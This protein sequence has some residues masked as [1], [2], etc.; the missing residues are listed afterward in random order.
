MMTDGA[1]THRMMKNGA[2]IEK[3]MMI[4]FATFKPCG[5][6]EKNTGSREG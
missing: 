4:G 1:E 2:K 3:N 5:W 6:G